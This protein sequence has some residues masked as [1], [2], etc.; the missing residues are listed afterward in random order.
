MLLYALWNFVFMLKSRFAHLLSELL[1]AIAI[2]LLSHS[3][4]P[5]PARTQAVSLP[6]VYI[7]N[8]NYGK[9]LKLTGS[10]K[11]NAGLWLNAGVPLQIL[12]KLSRG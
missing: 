2:P 3:L 6:R 4:L 5:F 12:R 11:R 9:S 7:A 8:G 10:G 1:Q